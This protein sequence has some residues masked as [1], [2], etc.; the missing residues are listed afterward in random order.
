MA[1]SMRAAAVRA[2]GHGRRPPPR[3]ARP[4]RRRGRNVMPSRTCARPAWRAL[5]GTPPSRSTGMTQTGGV[6]DL[7]VSIVEPGELLSS[8]G[9]RRWPGRSVLA[10]RPRTRARRR[11]EARAGPVGASSVV[12]LSGTVVHEGV[13]W[14]RAAIQRGLAG[15]ALP[16]V[17][18]RRLATPAVPV[19]RR[20][21]RLWSA[22]SV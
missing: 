10:D 19:A 9:T 8:R 14:Q 17:G 6:R 11:A 1:P 2:P 21:R 12:L 5:P 3:A 7:G 4:G 16:V 20:M 22:G 15:E 18:R 13:P